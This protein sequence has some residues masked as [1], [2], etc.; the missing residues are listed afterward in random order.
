MTGHDPQHIDQTG[1]CDCGAITLNA[2]G[3]VVSMFLC[4]CEN[5]QRSTGTGHSSVVVVHTEA[6]RTV[7]ATKAFSRP[8]ASG[9]VFTRQFCP[10]CGTTVF[11]QSSRAPALRIL[12]IGIFVNHNDWF[13]PNQLIFARSHQAWDLIE[14]HL[15]QHM[16]YREDGTP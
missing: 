8:A 9:A 6:I 11:G 16:A 7:G 12:P 3:R 5:C 13:A 14:D 10:E 2:Q 1:R 15:P 4:A